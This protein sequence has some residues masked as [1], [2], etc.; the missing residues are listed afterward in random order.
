MALHVHHLNKK[1]SISFYNLLQDFI[2]A[3]IK[4]EQF[5]LGVINL[6]YT[7]NTEILELNQKYLG[8]DYH[9]DV[10]SFTYDYNHGINGDVFISCDKAEENALEYHTSFDNELLRVTIHG[11]LHLIGYED[12]RPQEKEQMRRK[13]DHYLEYFKINFS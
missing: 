4:Q 1:F 8:H 3:L 12:S 2:P 7:D 10:I 13:E 11:I 6:I 9:T 5:T